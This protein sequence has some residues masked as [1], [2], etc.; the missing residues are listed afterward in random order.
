MGHPKNEMQTFLFEYDFAKDGGAIGSIPL[1]KNINALKEGVIVHKI[2]IRV[3][4]LLASGGTPTL[5]LGNTGDVDGYMTN[6]FG[7]NAQDAVLYSEQYA[8]ALLP[9]DD[10]YRVDATAA[11]Q[12][13]LME[14]GV[15]ALTAGKLD[16]ILH[17]TSDGK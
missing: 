16:I 4:T 14:V 8:G 5:T 7:G 6:F 2:E 3:K 9:V 11:N 10:V 15:A 12:D 13:L 17:C 1:R